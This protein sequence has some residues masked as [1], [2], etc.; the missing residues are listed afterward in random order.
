M[1][2][3]LH[4][5]SFYSCFRISCKRSDD[6][7]YTRKSRRAR[8]AEEEEV[9]QDAGAAAKKGASP[10]PEEES[11]YRRRRRYA[12]RDA[13]DDESAQAEAADERGESGSS[14][15][16]T[17]RAVMDS[18]CTKEMWDE[19]KKEKGREGKEKKEKSS[20]SSHQAVHSA[21][22]AVFGLR[23]RSDRY[24]TICRARSKVIQLLLTSTWPLLRVVVG[25]R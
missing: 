10:A 9:G 20:L 18:V 5:K 15:R 8:L 7:V 21:G 14:D 11:S 22:P 16:G 2:S 25:S 23:P 17:E 1:S 13:A 3:R 12:N 4:P 24:L 19:I 6:M